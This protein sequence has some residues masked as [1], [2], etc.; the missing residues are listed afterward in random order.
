[1]GI[2]MPPVVK[3][4]AGVNVT[5]SKAFIAATVVEANVTVLAATAKYAV[6]PLTQVWL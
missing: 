5:L 4:P 1:M 6:R 2:W 3:V